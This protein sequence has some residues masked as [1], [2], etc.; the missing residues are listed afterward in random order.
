[1]PLSSG[2][3]RALLLVTATLALSASITPVE[4]AQ[5]QTQHEISAAKAAFSAGLALEAAGDYAQALT[6][7]REVIAVKVTPQALFHI[8][9]CLE[10]LGK[11]TEAV[12]NYRLAIEKAEETRATEAGRE[13]DAARSAL[14]PKV[15][16]IVIRRGRGAAAASISIDGV[17]LGATAIDVEMPVDPGPHT[18]I[19]TAPGQK[20]TTVQVTVAEAETKN[21]TLDLDGP[22]SEP[23]QPVSPTTPGAW[24]WKRT[25]YAVGAVGLASLAAGGVFLALRQSTISK[26]DDQ[27]VGN[28]C[29]SSLE[30]TWDDG[31]KYTLL[32][33]TF[34]G[35][36]AVGVMAGA[37]LVLWGKDPQRSS[38]PPSASRAVLIPAASAGLGATVSGVF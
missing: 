21:V 17:A 22:R 14:E 9:R 10:R 15:P 26:L 12:G 38:S 32:A 24:N 2:P 35:I 36:G 16:K 20:A 4:T 8:G 11:W 30:G 31:K 25:G 5:A 7:F 33:N 13:A 6:R 1:M 28:H 19:A 3:R 27:C 37:G 34:L 23:G 29:P 18:L